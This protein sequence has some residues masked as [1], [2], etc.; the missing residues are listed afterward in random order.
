VE[1]KL[2]VKAELRLQSLHA[3]AASER[4]SLVEGI[5]GAAFHLPIPAAPRE[6]LDLGLPD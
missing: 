2:L 6:T 3:M 1:A 4:R 5:V